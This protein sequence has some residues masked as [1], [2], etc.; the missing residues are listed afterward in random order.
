MRRTGILIVSMVLLWTGCGGGGGSSTSPTPS[1]TFKSSTNASEEAIDCKRARA[2]V[3][4]P[5]GGPDAKVAVLDLSVDPDA[6]DVRAS[7]PS[8]GPMTRAA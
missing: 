5:G 7:P 2:Y 1:T 4:L 3:P 6:T 8:T